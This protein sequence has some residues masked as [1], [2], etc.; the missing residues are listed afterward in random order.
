[1]LSF[2]NE[3]GESRRTRLSFAECG[4]APAFQRGTTAKRASR[5]RKS[6]DAIRREDSCQGAAP[7][8][9]SL[10]IS[11]DGRDGSEGKNPFGLRTLHRLRAPRK[12]CERVQRRSETGQRSAPGRA[13][14]IYR[15]D[16]PSFHT[17]RRLRASARRR[18]LAKA[19]AIKARVRW[20]GNSHLDLAGV[21]PAPEV[22]HA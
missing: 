14:G 21:G 16:P 3:S 13:H 15:P 7:P 11:R 18:L 4:R 6:G 17:E 19:Q 12:I 9:L 10:T 2:S 20:H 22:A 8:C 5:Y 1:M